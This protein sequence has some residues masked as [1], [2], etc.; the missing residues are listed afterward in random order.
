M[1]EI[2]TPIACLTPYVTTTTM[3]HMA[4]IILALLCIPDRVTLLGLSRWMESGGSYRTLQRWSQT[5]LVWAQVL[6]AVVRSYLLHPTGRYLLAG[7]D[8]V[9]SK[10]GQATHGLGRFYSSLAGGVIPS[11]SFLVVSLIDIE[12]RRSYP[13]QVEQR[14]PPT[15]ASNAVPAGLPKHPRGRP[16]GSKNHA[17][18]VP[19]LTPELSLL[20][21][22][23]RAVCVRIVPLRVGHVVLDGFFGTYPAT[24]IV[25]QTGL[26]MISKL[27]H[28]AALYLPY[29]GPKP[30]RGPTPRY[31]QKLT[32]HALPPEALCQTVMQGHYRTDT[33]QVTALHHD[34]PDPL[35]VVILVKTNLRTG[36]T[37]HVVLFSTDLTLSAAQLVDYYNLRFQIE[38]NFRD[39]K[40]YW[41][42][43]DFM[44]VS[45]IALTNAVNLAF[46][47][48]NFST[49]LLLPHRQAQTDFSVLDLK[50]HYR[51]QRYL[52]ETI[53]CLPTLPTPDLI[54]L[55]R[56]K[57]SALGGLRTRQ[58]QKS[59]A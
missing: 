34:F 53:K 15:G 38:F 11:V 22:M 51:I 3:R 5:P 18:A 46:F 52:D 10:A 6:W 24:Y 55:I 42:L 56:Q 20:E 2:V 8:V 57:L 21:Q 59:P 36:R 7:D 37:S 23:L 45:P 19:T 35:N 44:N 54:S 29:A 16:K 47:M 58:L 30:V 1:G 4:Q 32:Y 13:L 26:H 41:G 25:Q 50:A 27:R 17:K 33:Y 9:D 12:R 43:E 40:Q 49:M 31:G 28:N 14:M 39:A 48:V